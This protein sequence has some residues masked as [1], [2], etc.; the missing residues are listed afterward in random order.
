MDE[1]ESIEQAITALEA[2]RPT[3]GQAQANYLEMTPAHREL[4]RLYHQ[5]VAG[6]D[7]DYP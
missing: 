1:I 7:K 2:Q 4:Q 6:I 5:L 3:A